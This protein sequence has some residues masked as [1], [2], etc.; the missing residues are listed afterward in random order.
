MMLSS[1][2]FSQRKVSIYDEGAK[3]NTGTYTLPAGWQAD[4][5]I[6]TDLQNFSQFFHY[7][8]FDF[9]GPKKEVVR[10]VAPVEGG[11]SIQQV[12]PATMQQQL[13]PLGQFQTGNWQPSQYATY[14]FPQLSGNSGIQAIECPVSG[15]RSG[16][17]FE[18][19]C[20]ALVSNVGNSSS[21]T[22]VIILAPQ[23]RLQQTVQT[24]R[25][26]FSSKQENPQY[27]R[28]LQQK[29]QRYVSQ[30]QQMMNQRQQQFDQFQQNMRDLS[31]ARSRNNASFNAY[32]RGGQGSGG[33]S[34][35][36]YSNNDK[37]NDY[38]KETTSFDD[39]YYGH[40]ISV[41]GVY[42]H[43]YT[44]GYGHYY[45][46]NDPSFDPASLNG[47]WKKVTPLN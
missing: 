44:D 36:N 13:S 29:R 19:L 17:A 27:T 14:L 32:L 31:D 42:D 2:I 9:V 41:Q 25:Q 43:W 34:N 7:Y 39:G 21:F 3:M 40:Q 16:Q 5:K 28:L 8:K 18:G 1:F 45:G 46:T 6:A 26:I 22:A 33:T 11:A 24:A 30:S 37:F 38:L 4:Y 20:I 23:H 35:G 15:Y 12:L 47:Y 10:N